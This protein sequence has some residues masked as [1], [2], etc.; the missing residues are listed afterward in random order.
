VVP[1]GPE[2]SLACPFCGAEV[3]PGQKFC[4]DCGTRLGANCTNCG[5]PLI[6]G[7]RFCG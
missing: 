3:R 5:A 1:I 6:E 7:A 2:E 4:F